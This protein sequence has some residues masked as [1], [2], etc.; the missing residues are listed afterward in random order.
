VVQLESIGVAFLGKYLFR[1][2][3]LHISDGDRVGLVGPNG[4]GK[5]TLLRVICSHLTPD[6]GKINLTKGTEFGY[7]PQEEVAVR[8]RT[9]Y[10]EALSA[11]GS[12]IKLRDEQ[13]EIEKALDSGTLAAD[14]SHRLLKR[15]GELQ[16]EFERKD[17]YSIRAR[18]ES[19]LDGLGFKKDEW[20]KMS[21]DF[22]G[23]WQMRI[24]LAKI[25][26]SNPD[27]LLFDE[28]TNHLDLE[29]M[30]WLEEYLDSFSGTIV[31]VSHDRYF[32]DRI[33][34]K[35]VELELGKLTPYNMNYSA[36]LED[37]EKREANLFEAQRRQ[38]ER[39]EQLEKFIRRYKV[40]AA[41]V[42][43]AKSREKVL[44]KMER[45]DVLP[46]PKS[47]HFRFP[48]APR[49]ARRALAL[50]G[51]SKSYGTN[52]VLE[53]VNFTVERGDRIA[54]AGVN[55]AGK[56]TLLKMIAGVEPPTTGE[57]V[58]GEKV[59]IQYFS[60]QTA[61]MLDLDRTVLEEVE[62]AAPDALQQELRGLLGAFL[63]SGDDVFKKVRVLS[64]GEKCRLAIAKTLL[65]PS[66]VLILDEPTNHLDQR[67][68]D[69]FEKALADYKGAFVL[70]THDRYLIDRLAKKVILVKGGGIR[71]YL[72][73]YTDYLWMA[74]E[75][76]PVE[77]KAR[78]EEKKEPDKP[79]RKD[80]KRKEALERQKA[81]EKKMTARAVED[82]IEAVEARVTE[83]ENTLSDAGVYKDEK[84]VKELVYEDRDLR[85]KL[86]GL[87][88]KLEAVWAR[89]EHE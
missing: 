9:L 51:V 80:E 31:V 53:N 64:G 74:K 72:G 54:V 17:G 62:S 89:Q 58:V 3:T 11:L 14:E 52:R 8:G 69:V 84:R 77:K 61:D 39:I 2:L 1:N 63:F 41:K 60:Q 25:L 79:S 16:E 45:I 71:E 19:I 4:A 27:V 67:G 68:R 85:E 82:K 78:P 29:S 70:V 76:R 86:E 83:I 56:S 18:T 24:A 42:A 44:E 12:V 88:K 38:Q 55:G 23:G 20:N 43:Q 65:T 35:T 36:Y 50:S 49:C 37:K 33:A 81:Y 28:P 21:E 59:A 15:Y 66:N 7:L 40:Q 73:N 57:R 26:L 30:T 13:T 34:R 87:Y 32:M 6:E 10:D 22:S 46:T 48:P 47:M 5:T 75:D